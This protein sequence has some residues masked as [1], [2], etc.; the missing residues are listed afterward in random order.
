MKILSSKQIFIYLKKIR[1][2]SSLPRELSFALNGL[3]ELP[4]V[5]FNQPRPFSS[6]MI[7]VSELHAPIT[8]GRILT[9]DKNNPFNIERYTFLAIRFINR[10]FDPYCKKKDVNVWFLSPKDGSWRFVSGGFIGGW[11]T[12]FPT[13]NGL[14]DDFVKT[15]DYISRLVEGYISHLDENG[16]EEE[17]N[18][19]CGVRDLGSSIEHSKVTQLGT[20]TVVLA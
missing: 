15:I 10:E 11:P 3:F 7:K 14:G 12:R 2:L 5:N 13:K 1:F 19:P 17:V 16:V 20:S 6:D 8:V 4:C 18:N 9:I